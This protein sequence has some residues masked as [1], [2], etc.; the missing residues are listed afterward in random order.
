MLL[1]AGS[2]LITAALLAAL[3]GCAGPGVSG[4]PPA[5]GRRAAQ[6]G[7]AVPGERLG[8]LA[9]LPTSGTTAERLGALAGQPLPLCVKAPKGSGNASCHVQTRADL[10]PQ[11]DPQTPYEKIAGY[12]PHD[13]LSA[14]TIPAGLGQ[15]RRVAI[16]AAYDD[17]ALESD[18]AVYRRAMGLPPCTSASGCF[19]KVT[20]RTDTVDPG[21][22]AEMALDVEMVSAICPLCSI[23]VVEA[24][25]P[26]LHD[27]AAAVD[28]A[29]S[30]RPDAI[31]NS[32]YADEEP[33]ERSVVKH[34]SVPGIALTAA[35]GDDGYGTT[36]PA[37]LATVTAV[38]GTS[39]IPDQSRRGWSEGVWRG[40]GSGCS[41]LM[42]K[43][44]WQDDTGCSG[45]T[46]ADVSIVA[47][48]RTGV[49]MY[50]SVAPGGQTGWIV[51]GGTSVGAP[52]AAALYALAGNASS[53][54]GARLLWMRRSAL[55][56]VTLGSNGSCSVAYLCAA[57]VGYS[58]PA[59]NG[60]PAGLGAF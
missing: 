57:T 18:L 40:S 48:P 33:S 60:S 32:Y 5:S 28:V 10:A 17:P 15:G 26:A 53:L 13:L 21:W 34:Y 49:A 4:A 41:T 37:S 30:Y 55:W 8:A 20:T 11:P 12:K 35:A 22:S 19:T 38:G 14:Y 9:G 16:V 51:G 7:A 42:E 36:F 59:G 43:P 6:D 54:S 50:T 29:V 24:A 39:L 31:S 46:I 58:G 3:S 2:I 44:P 52:V 45:R 47:D 1:R 23:V 27:L 25:S 56:P